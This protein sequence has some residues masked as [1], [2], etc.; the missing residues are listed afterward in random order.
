MTSV[1][2]YPYLLPGLLTI[3]GFGA[4]SHYLLKENVLKLD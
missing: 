4:L 1:G 3:Q 2:S